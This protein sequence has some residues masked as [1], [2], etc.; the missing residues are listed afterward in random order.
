M[1]M[2]P[3]VPCPQFTRTRSRCGCRIRRRTRAAKT[4]GNGKHIPF[5]PHYLLVGCILPLLKARFRFFSGRS[6][7][8]RVQLAEVGRRIH[9]KF[10]LPAPERAH[11][12]AV[13]APH[14]QLP[15]RAALGSPPQ[16]IR[17]PATHSEPHA[18]HLLL[19]WGVTTPLQVLWAL[20]E[21]AVPPGDAVE[22]WA[23]TPPVFFYGRSC[24][25]RVRL[26][27]VG[28]RIHRKIHLPAPERA[29]RDAVPAPHSQLPSR[30]ALGSPPQEI[31]D[32]ATH[33]EPHAPHLLL[34]WGVTTLQVLWAVVRVPVLGPL[35]ESAA[36]AGS[37]S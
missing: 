9:R 19:S 29:H 5:F 35:A 25:R 23:L 2:N 30:A 21:G 24:Y 32:P 8:R 3:H 10:H 18:P 22:A 1:R 27:E 11:R 36:P 4:S 37:R 6:C 7:Y 13:P 17:D 28:R 16:E 14:S 20:P 12:D 31:R 15:S 33:S 34:S 26:A